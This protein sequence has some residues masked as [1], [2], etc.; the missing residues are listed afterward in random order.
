[1][2]VLQTPIVRG[3]LRVSYISLDP[4]PRSTT[5]ISTSLTLFV[6]HWFL[7]KPSR[8]LHPRRAHMGETYRYIQLVKYSRR[9]T[10]SF[11]HRDSTATDK[12]NI[13]L[14]GARIVTFNPGVFQ[15]IKP[16]QSSI[17]SFNLRGHTD[18]TVSWPLQECP[19]FQGNVW[20]LVL[21]IPFVLEMISAVPFVIT[22]STTSQ[23]VF[24]WTPWTTLRSK[25][26]C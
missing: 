9:L 6:L 19:C 3:S 11:S 2:F 21:R 1:M 5:C 7:A 10:P 12:W 24:L 16:N 15:W 22:V 23:W 26:H 8:P 14:R 20:E 17:L 4:H 13:S 25:S 18:N